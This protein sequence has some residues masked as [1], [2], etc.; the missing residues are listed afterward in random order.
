VSTRNVV[1]AVAA[2]G[3]REQGTGTRHTAPGTAQGEPGDRWSSPS[4]DSV[5]FFD[6]GFV[7]FGFFAVFLIFVVA[8]GRDARVRF[9]AGFFD[10]VPALRTG[11]AF[12]GVPAART[13]NR[14]D[15]S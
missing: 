10:A 9:A 15:D 13:L 11:P 6:A 5:R 1:A 4:Q 3:L 12:D 14:S 8:S 7:I 2:A